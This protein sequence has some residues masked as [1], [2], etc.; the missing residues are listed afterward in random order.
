MKPFKLNVRQEIIDSAK[1]SHTAQ[2]MLAQAWRVQHRANSIN[3][4]SEKAMFSIEGT[5]YLCLIPKAVRSKVVN[6]DIDKKTVKPF[7]FTV[8]PFASK[9]VAKRP[10][11]KKRGPTKNR[12]KPTKTQCK[13]RYHGLSLNGLKEVLHETK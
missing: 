9:P 12:N 13:R 5:R 4:T 6:F 11:A 8:K 10:N 3:V 2:C 1:S 7:T